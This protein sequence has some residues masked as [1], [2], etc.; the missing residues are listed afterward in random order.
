MHSEIFPFVGSACGVLVP[1]TVLR[2]LGW[3]RDA[4]LNPSHHCASVTIQ[5]GAGALVAPPGILVGTSWPH[6]EPHETPQ[7]T[8]D[9][10]TWIEV[11]GT[12]STLTLW[13]AAYRVVEHHAQAVILDAYRPR[14]AWDGSLRFTRMRVLA[15]VKHPKLIGT[16]AWSHDCGAHCE[17]SESDIEDAKEK[18]ADAAE[19]AEEK[20]N[21]QA[22]AHALERREACE[23]EEEENAAY[24]EVLLPPCENAREAEELEEGIREECKRVPSAPK[25][26]LQPCS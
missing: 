6:Q 2:Q 9:G 4:T 11:R 13:G 21:E 19:K 17:D 22:S 1:Y 14:T 24:S 18:A 16:I 3:A 25:P 15:P 12:G 20:A 23:A 5:T 10:A 8:I 26:P 7:F